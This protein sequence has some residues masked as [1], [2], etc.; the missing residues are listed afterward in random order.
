MLNNNLGTS[1]LDLIASEN[2]TDVIEQLSKN[3]LS[4]EL[5]DGFTGGITEL[6][7]IVKHFAKAYKSYRNGRD[8]VLQKKLLLFL[9]SLENLSN[10]AR[11][12]LI[13]K[14][15]NDEDYRQTVGDN[16]ILILDMLD[17]IKKPKIL[18]NFFKAYLEKEFSFEVFR[19]LEKSLRTISLSSIEVLAEFYAPEDKKVEEIV[20]MSEYFDEYS[21]QELISA[22]LITSNRGFLAQ[23]GHKAGCSDNEL[24][25]LFLKYM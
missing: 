13:S 1:T 19:K 6:L 5:L 10:N 12:E 9:E 24:G 22:G 21:I 7:P 2:I 25:N 11:Q 4:T 3:A 16:L 14:M 23:K 17:D 15:K 20:S 8:Y 18:G